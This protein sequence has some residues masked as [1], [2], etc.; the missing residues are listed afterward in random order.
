MGRGTR[1]GLGHVLARLG[2]IGVLLGYCG[3]QTATQRCMEERESCLAKCTQDE[4]GDCK[5]ACDDAVNKC[6]ER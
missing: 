2:I 5:K 6:M 4:D 3:C 1:G